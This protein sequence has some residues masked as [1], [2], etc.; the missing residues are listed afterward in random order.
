MT[1]SSLED[2]R[3]EINQ[4]REYIQHL[5]CVNDV[6]G[7]VA[8][9][10]DSEQIKTLLNILKGHQRAFRID[11]KIFEYKAI[12]ISLYGILEKFIEIWIK[13]YLDRLSNI[14]P[15]YTQIDEKM[16]EKHFELS[17]KLISTITSRES[18]KYQHLTK[19]QVL[20]NLNNGIQNPSNYKFNTEAFVLFSGNLK[21]NKIVELFKPLN[22]DLNGK[23]KIN[24]TL[25]QHIQYERQ[26]ENIANLET[27]VLYEQINDLVERRN[28]IAHGS[29]MIENILDH[30]VLENYLQFLEKYCQAI[31]EIL[32]EEVIKQES[33]Y[34]FQKIENVIKIFKSEILAFEIENY[35]LK[36]GEVIIIETAEGLFFKKPILDIRVD[37]ISY[38]QMTIKNKM[39]VTIKLEP[40][41]Q[42][43]QKFFLRKA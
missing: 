26:K 25:V 20:S 14:V 4:I 38:P 27:A 15:E 37:D 43:N 41:I 35:E 6:A 23:L 3:K 2:F 36:V 30:S 40:K 34:H 22:I 1:I 16:R 10:T 8:L 39:T 17:L 29:E 21:H 5:Q 18:A 19:E 24:Q 28:E 13:E 31:F 32:T 9:E 11:K 33:V 42:K 12:I 7:Y